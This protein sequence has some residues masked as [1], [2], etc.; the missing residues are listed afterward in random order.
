M[1][2]FLPMSKFNP[3]QIEIETVALEVLCLPCE[4]VGRILY[5][6]SNSDDEGS[7]SGF[8]R[9]NA[10]TPHVLPS[11]RRRGIIGAWERFVPVLE[12]LIV[13]M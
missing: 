6:A 12:M 4:D 10:E 13:P 3:T 9:W 5:F 1:L 8:F 2:V 11:F 7:E